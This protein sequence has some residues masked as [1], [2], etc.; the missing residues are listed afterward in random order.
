MQTTAVKIS[1]IK[2]SIVFKFLNVKVNGT[3]LKLLW[4]KLKGFLA[5]FSASLRDDRQI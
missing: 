1:E 2:R 3:P 5:E 4:K